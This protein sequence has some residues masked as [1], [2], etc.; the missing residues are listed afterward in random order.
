MTLNWKNVVISVDLVSEARKH[1]EF[2]SY[3]DS[4][5]VVYD[6][7]VLE[8]AIY[9][10]ETHWLPICAELLKTGVDISQ[11]Y[12]PLDVAWVKW[13]IKTYKLYIYCI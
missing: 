8:K 6:R 1:I 10:Y 5:K 12:P 9:R 11:F 7:N 3:I 4:E 13:S 2:L